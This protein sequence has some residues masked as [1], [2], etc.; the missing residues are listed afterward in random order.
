MIH[1]I[2]GDILESNAQALVNTVNIMGIMGKGIAFQFK[3][4]YPNNFKAYSDACKRKEID[5]GKL[6][7]TKDS[8]LQSGDKIIINFPT[9]KDWRKPSEYRFIEEGLNDLVKV[10]KKY[11]IKSIAIP[12]LGAGNGGLHWVT[13]KQMIAEKLKGKDID[14][15]IYE[16]TTQI[17][18]C[19][20]KERTKLTEARALLLYVLYDLVRNG[21][22]VSEFSSEKVCYFLQKFGAEKYLKLEFSPKFYGPYSGKVRFVLNALNGSYIMGYSDMNKKP[23]DPLSIVVDGYE[24]VKNKIEQNKEL[25]SIAN[26]TMNFLNGFY[27]DFSLEL[28]SSVDYIISSS[29]TYDKESIYNQLN[30]WN[31]RK[32]IM[33]SDVKYVDIAVEHIQNFN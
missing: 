16:P 20:K 17:E 30:I 24:L 9:K 13:V 19:L 2:T 11:D 14:I 26:N 1:Y 10:I 7:V 3:K 33:F 21:E 31:N 29:D 23:F 25:F 12:P 15:Y 5:I 4:A 27:S 32:H 28:L 22:Y 18:E 8:N 6:F